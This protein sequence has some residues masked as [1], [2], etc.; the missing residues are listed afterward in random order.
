MFIVTIG[1]LGWIFFSLSFFITSTKSLSLS[2][3]PS[4]SSSSSS[5]SSFSPFSLSD[6][7]SGWFLFLFS[8]NCLCFFWLSFPLTY[9]LYSF[10]AL[11]FWVYLV[12]F[13]AKPF[14]LYLF[15]SSS[16]SPSSRTP[17]SFSSFSS[18]LLTILSLIALE[19][20]VFSY[21]QRE[22][23]SLSLLFTTLSY[24]PSL[25]FHSHL[26]KDVIFFFFISLSL[27]LFLFLP[28]D[29]G[30]QP[31]LIFIGGLIGLSLFLL[32]AF[33]HPS[34]LLSISPPSLALSF[35]L[36]SLFPLFLLFCG[37]VGISTLS[38]YCF[39]NHISLSP[40]SHL[41]CWFLL[42]VTPFV[43][44]SVIR[45]SPSSSSSSSLL[46]LSFPL[47]SSFFAIGS[48]YALLTISYELIF[49]SFFFL[50]LLSWMRVESK[51][52][53]LISYRSS[54]SPLPLST[55]VSLFFQPIA[56]L[57]RCVTYL[58]YCHIA[59]FGTGNFASLTSFDLSSTYRFVTVFSPF[60]MGALLILKVLLP[61]LM[62]ALSFILIHTASGVEAGPSLIAVGG[63]AD[64]LTINFFFFVRDHG[65]WFEIG[66]SISHFAMAD[67]LLVFQLSI[68][69]LATFL[70][71]RFI[72]SFLEKEVKGA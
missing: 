18:I 5:S 38:S 29:S 31:L 40:F 68:F 9:Y 57:R 48:I 33:L 13:R 27:S 42:F 66:Q 47:L 26:R 44:V 14:F 37:C 20:V 36:S 69:G 51:N 63:L 45:S 11:F 62:L 60:L 16:S 15:S 65:S 54:S 10:F 8:F 58:V 49:F 23:L 34:R 41:F 53:L 19:V 1:Y 61:F 21:Y 52:H 50:C 30:D 2:F 59:F 3:S 22:A 39:L 7:M 25:F 17:S 24:S 56:E 35:S 46:P 70:L 12:I 64:I 67:V 4:P 55:R 71:G 6:M 32:S 43:Y 72:S 28:T